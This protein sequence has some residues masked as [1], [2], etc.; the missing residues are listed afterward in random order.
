MLGA[1]D[2]FV[3][4]FKDMQDYRYLIKDTTQRKELID[5]VKKLYADKVGANLPIYAVE[6]RNLK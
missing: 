2:D 3:L 5:T 6:A 4:H 1:K